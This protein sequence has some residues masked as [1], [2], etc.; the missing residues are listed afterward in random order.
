MMILLDLEGSGP[1]VSAY[2]IFLSCVVINL[3]Q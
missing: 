3:M 2:I 1:S